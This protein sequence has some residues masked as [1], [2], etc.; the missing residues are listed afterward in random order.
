MR[1]K[2]KRVLIVDDEPD[3]T[4]V[5]KQVLDENG[6]EADSYDEPRLALN[7]FKANMYDL[8][9]LDI[10]MPDING[11]DLYQEMRKIDDKVK[12][13]FLT[14]SEM[15]YEKFRKEE[16]YSK[17]DKELFIAKPIENEELLD[18]LNKVINNSN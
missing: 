2:K 11:L 17:F 9:L 18:H 5:L 10:K 4:L 7:N 16:P 1:N 12:V 8:L 14:A 13:C 15:F 6:F 3:V